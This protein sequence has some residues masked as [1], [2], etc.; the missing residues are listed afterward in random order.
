MQTHEGM[1][2]K[3]TNFVVIAIILSIFN[4]NVFAQETTGIQLKKPLK[5]IVSSGWEFGLQRPVDFPEIAKQLKDGPY[6]G[7]A[8]GFEVVS[9][10]D[11]NFKCVLS[12]AWKNV[13]WKKEWFKK[14][15]E[16]LK[17]TPKGKLTDNFIRVYLNTA[18]GSKDPAK[19]RS[20]EIEDFILKS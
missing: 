15:A 11:P 19:D 10:E 8:L 14:N 9:T 12:N 1:Q 16:L 20:Q 13:R 3:N 5:K 2:M 17:S 6:D 7:I 18:Y 4:I